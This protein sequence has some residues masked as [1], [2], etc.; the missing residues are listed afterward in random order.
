MYKITT[1]IL[2][3]AVLAG[4]SS[5]PIEQ[6]EYKARLDYCE[7]IGM[8]PEIEKNEKS[9]PVN[10]DCIDDHGSIFDSKTSK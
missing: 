8:K 7:S 3:V 2:A 1:I 10:V 4:C 9:R 5:S 6:K